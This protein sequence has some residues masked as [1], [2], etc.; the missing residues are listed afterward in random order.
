MTI[1]SGRE[2]GREAVRGLVAAF[3]ANE[4]YFRSRDYTETAAR[5]Q[6]VDALLSALGWDVHDAAGRGA[7]R[8]VVVE[9]MHRGDGEVAGDTSWDD[10]LDESDLAE[11]SVVTS[12]PDYLVRLDLKNLYVVEAKKPSVNLHWKAPAFQ[13]KSYAWSMRLPIAVLTD[14]EELRVFDARYRP[15]YERPEAGVVPHLDLRY[16][17]YVAEWDRLWD[18]LSREGVAA[19]S[20]DAFVAAAS[21]RGAQ[22]VDRAFLSELATW[23]VAVASDLKSRNPDLDRWEIAEATQRLLDRVVFIRI[24]ED[25]GILGELLL[26]RYARRADSYRRLV[27]EFRQLDAVYN[28][29]LFAEHFSERL[30][31]SDAV[32]QRLVEALYYPR[33]PYRFDA[34]GSDLLGSIYERFLGQEITIDNRGQIDATDKPEVRHAGGVYY[35]PAWVVERIV[36]TT[37]GPLVAGKTPRAVANLRILDP[38]CGSGAFLLGAFQYLIRWHEHY[39]DEHPNE[40]PGSHFV[41][42]TGERR[43]TPD[44]KAQILANNLYGVDIDPQAVEVTQMSLYIAMLEGENSAS[45][46]AQQRLF[47]SAFLPKLDRNI[48]CGNS[49]IA[50]TDLPDD[51]LFGA[52][53]LRRRVNAFDWHD[54]RLGFGAVFQSRRGFDAVIGNPPY[55][56]IQVLRRYRPDEADTYQRRYASASEGSF[57]ISMP[58]IER[59]ME[60]LRPGG[61]LGYI[62]SRQ[63]CETTSGEQLRRMLSAGRHVQEIVDFVDG[64]VFDGASAYTLLLF[65]SSAA[66]PAYRLTRVAPPP[67][68]AG[69]SAAEAATSPFSALI[70]ASTLG[71]AEWTLDLPAE[72][73]LL[74]R[75]RNSHPTLG[76]VCG[77]VVFQGVVTGADYVFRLRDLGPL[78]GQNEL[79][80]V[81]R[82]DTSVE[83]VIEARLLRPVLGGRSDIRRFATADESEVL[84]LP[85]ER[86]PGEDRYSLLASTTLRR[87]YPNAWQWLTTHRAELAERSGAW[88]EHDWWSFARRQNLELFD[89]PKI[90][91]PYMIDHLCAHHDTANHY[92]VNVTTGGYGIPAANVADPEFLAALLNSRLLSWILRRYSRAFRGGWFAARKA[93]LIRLPIAET[94]VSTRRHICDLYQRCVTA[95]REIA[96]TRS[97]GALD[98]AE[99]ALAAAV[100]RFDDAVD[101]LYGLTRE[102]TALVLSGVGASVDDASAST[103]DE[104]A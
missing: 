17:R 3:A 38:A 9:N 27:A 23:R 25:R 20:L 45:L 50:P 47:Q 34:I 58:F 1:A 33:C 7:R 91:V 79:R 49:L 31:V 87:E 64:R 78:P 90:L 28:G 2:D 77:G 83:G 80:Q 19:G 6:F 69:L 13:A 89:E 82:R 86:P 67:T 32:F 15:E 8:D 48:R 62:V 12:F 46:H 66:S 98:L 40:T 16:D 21:P 95:K 96:N 63:F 56:R 4:L 41:T 29:Q 71:S 44:A 68:G 55:T 99:R 42:S 22:P 39:Y 72:A 30:D 14:F 103:D 65:A 61:R 11:R 18:L 104:G 92:F 100:T 26:R 85:Y 97:G 10:D 43:L 76:T 60:L 37:L 88:G 93:N 52:D 81:A 54:D 70:N 5:S 51:V 36:A 84:L 75:L 102:E 74:D 53:E 57:D 35:T 24:M 59:G 94:E 73:D 101:A